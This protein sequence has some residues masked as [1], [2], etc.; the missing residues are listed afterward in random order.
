MIQTNS[1]PMTNRKIL[2]V[3]CLTVH[4]LFFAKQSQLTAQSSIEVS[5]SPSVIQSG[6]RGSYSSGSGG[7]YSSG[8]SFQR[9]TYY[10]DIKGFGNK[11]ES[12]G[13]IKVTFHASK[14]DKLGNRCNIAGRVEYIADGTARPVD[15]FQ[16]IAVYLGKAP[17]KEC[18][19]ASGIS[20][21][22]EHESA[23]LNNDGSFEV[24]FDLRETDR[25]PNV[26]ARHQIGISFASSSNKNKKQQKITWSSTDPAI[27]ETIQMFELPAS[28]EIAPELRLIDR[29]SSW[30]DS[31]YDGIKLVRAVNALQPLG[32]ER[33]LEL[34]LEYTNSLEDT[35][36]DGN[37]VF[38]IIRL[39]FEPVDLG[40]QIPS[41]AIYMSFDT[42]DKGNY[43]DGY[44][45]TWPLDP[46]DLSHD[47]P[48][49]LGH[50]I[51]GS[52]RPE[53]PN[54]HI[55][56]ATK[57]GVIRESPL[58]PENPLVAADRLLNS[59]KYK[60]LPKSQ[61]DPRTDRI[62]EQAITMCKA[63]D[64]SEDRDEISGAQWDKLLKSAAATKIWN[65][66][67]Q[68]FVS[69]SR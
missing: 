14:L 41:P 47:V 26:K 23:I 55:T 11:P 45:V 63:T 53:H 48:F 27:Q 54:S 56:W 65:V 24:E 62:R 67:K 5:S 18:D 52:G 4:V 10:E 50:G 69:P 60:S 39:L 8:D 59:K 28:P 25:N 49:M 21:D 58:R 7:W 3:F 61:W 32:K 51:G 43:T 29:A 2:I 46:I 17:E 57:F 68:H 20:A 15:W 13:E 40:Q 16:G 44:S 64:L 9:K 38:W 30:P 66:E 36:D 42:G 12:H 33:A 19:W 1:S 37:I 35:Y 6:Q 22:T 31:N 34:L